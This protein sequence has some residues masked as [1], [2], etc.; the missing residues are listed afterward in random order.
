MYLLDYPV[1]FYKK[2]ILHHWEHSKHFYI[3]GIFSQQLTLQTHHFSITCDDKYMIM[4]LNLVWCKWH[5]LIE[6]D[7]DNSL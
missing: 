5:I 4:V 6:E 2:V 1:L 7:K 3:R